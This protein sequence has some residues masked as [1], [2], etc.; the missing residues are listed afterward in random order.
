MCQFLQWWCES[1]WILF[2]TGFL[3]RENKTGARVWCLSGCSY[4]SSESRAICANC[5]EYYQRHFTVHWKTVIWWNVWISGPLFV[6]CFLGVFNMKILIILKHA[7]WPHLTRTVYFCGMRLGVW[8]CPSRLGLPGSWLCIS[9]L[10]RLVFVARAVV[11][12]TVSS[13][14]CWLSVYSP[15]S[16][17]DDRAAGLSYAPLCILWPL[18]L[19]LIVP[20]SCG[21][22]RISCAW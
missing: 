12:Q 22:Y 20:H 3:S 17:P 16:I 21:I 15:Y 1:M 5:C 14:N 8:W 19:V 9:F 2:G 6:L 7:Y 11:C 10:C 4:G 18:S 13:D